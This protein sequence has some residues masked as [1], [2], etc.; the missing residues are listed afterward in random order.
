MRQGK[1]VPERVLTVLQRRSTAYEDAI[2]PW[3]IAQELHLPS[4]R[5]SKVVHDLHKQGRVSR[6]GRTFKGMRGRGYGYYLRG[7]ESPAP[8]MGRPRKGSAA[9]K[10]PKAKPQPISGMPELP[11]HGLSRIGAGVLDVVQG[12]TEEFDARLDHVAGKLDRLTASI[13]RLAAAQERANEQ[14]QPPPAPL[15]LPMVTGGMP[16][17]P[18]GLVDWMCH[19]ESA[20]AHQAPDATD[21]T[22]DTRYKVLIVGLLP[23]QENKI[24]G[25]YNDMLDLRFLKPGGRK[26]DRLVSLAKTSDTVITLTKFVTHSDED[27]LK[28]AGVRITRVNGGLSMLRRVLDEIYLER[29]A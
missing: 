29:V 1:S 6:T 9:K 10:R 8:T 14:R 17:K 28:S 18:R 13:E 4:E 27:A 21:T 25:D 23:S 2:P 3:D 16:E 11:L 19:G 26:S 15:S 22:P 24:N 20:E 5:I 7:D 12:L